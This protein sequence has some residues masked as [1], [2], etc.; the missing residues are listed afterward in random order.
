MNLESTNDIIAAVQAA[1][2]SPEPVPV[3]PVERPQVVRKPAATPAVSA[4]ASQPARTATEYWTL[5]GLCWN[6]RVATSFGDLPV[7]ALR[8]RDPLRTPSGSFAQVAH[9]D[10][11]R[12]DDGYLKGFPD[13]HP[14]RIE[15]G[16]L[17]NGKPSMP[18]LVSPHQRI[19][20]GDARYA[21][22]MRMARDLLERPGVTRQPQESLSYFVFHCGQPTSVMVEGIWVATTP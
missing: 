5:P 21:V 18:I 3:A 16:A 19:G 1:L 2:R 15:A 6:V 12:L 11:I 4:P 10:T 22:D 9:V 17:G 7:Q 13:A 8:T 20:V 14:I